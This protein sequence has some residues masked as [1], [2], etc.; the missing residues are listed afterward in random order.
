MAALEDITADT[1][2]VYGLADPRSDVVR[3]VGKS[4]SGL[5]RPKHHFYQSVRRADRTHKGAWLRQLATVG[6]KPSIKILE[7][8]SEDALS[9]REV[10]WVKHGLAQGWPL[11]NHC[12]G[13]EGVGQPEE[14]YKKLS[15]LFKNKPVS[16]ERLAVLQKN[17]ERRKGIPRDALTRNKLSVAAKKQFSSVEG[18]VAVSKARGGSAVRD[19]AGREFP[20][21]SE[22]A[23]F[24]GVFVTNIVKVLRGKRRTA[25]GFSFIYA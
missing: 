3:Y 13:G 22:A 1:C 2:L 10:F 11:C 16:P 5:S 7:V 9:V 21:A 12:V 4:T 24:H 20:S 15:A 25:G 8:V 17:A 23:R 19:S 18:R 6:L 14:H